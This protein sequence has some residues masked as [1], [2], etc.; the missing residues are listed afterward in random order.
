MRRIESKAARYCSDA[1]SSPTGLRR[2]GF[3]LLELLVVI[4]IIAVLAALLLPRSAG[5]GGRQSI[6]CVNQLRQLWLATRLYA[7]DNPDLFPRS[8]HSAFANRQLRGNA[9]WLRSSA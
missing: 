7:D 6:Q 3:T 5:E 8:Q 4:A 9:P 2:H 1:T